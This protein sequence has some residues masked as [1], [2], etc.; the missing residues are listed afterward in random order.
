MRGTSSRSA[1][2]AQRRAPGPVV[3][4]GRR[5]RRA[6]HEPAPAPLRAVE[7]LAE[8]HRRGR[9]LRSRRARCSIHVWPPPGC[10]PSCR[11]RVSKRASGAG[12]AHVARQRQVHA[13]ADGGAVDRGDGRAAGTGRPAGSP[14]RSRRSPTSASS[15]DDPPTRSDRSAPAQNAGGR[16]GDAPRR[17]PRCGLERV[18][19]GARSRRTIAR[20][21]ALRRRGSS[22]SHGRDVVRQIELDQ[23]HRSGGGLRAAAC[24][25]CAR[26]RGSGGRTVRRRAR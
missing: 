25:D 6:P 1:R 4:R 2:A 12:Q 10:R 20:L 21:S 23:G 26:P 8:E 24:A 22:Q 17:R 13:G 9:G 11:K 3:E 16:A 14:R 19:G 15:C 5:R 7:H 18:E